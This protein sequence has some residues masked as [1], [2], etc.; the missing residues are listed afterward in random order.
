LD[1]YD[2]S[3]SSSGGAWAHRRQRTAAAESRKVGEHLRADPFLQPAAAVKA[4]FIARRWLTAT[5]IGIGCALATLGLFP[6]SVAAVDP[7]DPGR[8][9]WHDLMAQD[10]AAAR[11][12]YSG[13]LGW[14]FESTIR[15]D[16]PYALARL[17]GEPVAG[18]VD[19][20]S[21]P[22]A[23]P[24]WISFMAVADVDKT[25]GLVTSGGGKVLVGPREIASI[26]RAAVVS[27]PQGAPLGV[28]Q[29]HREIQGVVDPTRPV[30]RRFFWHEYLA[31]DAARALEFYRGLAGYESAITDTRLE[32]EY[33]VLRTATRPRAGLFQL[34]ASSVVLPTWLPYVLVDDPAAVAARA[35]GLGGRILLPADP[36]RRNGSL[37][38]IADPGGAPL[39]LQ[40]YPF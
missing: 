18:L 30:A 37:V 21:L 33:H 5:W 25:V 13:L 2:A 19:V 10:V 32:V 6:T 40:R 12:F 11:R 28:A 8:F 39:A 34:P 22:D 26:A 20:S 24:Q 36:A 35:S 3:R 29:L 9:V 16:R 7:P 15:G 38:V 31:G 17:G 14:Q 1:A 23:A 4:N 27:D